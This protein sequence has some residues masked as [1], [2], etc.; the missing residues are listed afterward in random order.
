[1][2]NQIRVSPDLIPPVLVPQS[3]QNTDCQQLLRGVV[4]DS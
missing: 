1:M 2:T 3:S 4:P